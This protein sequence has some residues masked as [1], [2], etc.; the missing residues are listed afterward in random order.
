MYNYVCMCTFWKVICHEIEFIQSHGFN[1][2]F[3]AVFYQ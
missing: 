1:V 2:Y 3:L